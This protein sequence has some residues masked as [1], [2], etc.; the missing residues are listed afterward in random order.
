MEIERSLWTWWNPIVMKLVRIL[1][2]NE[3]LDRIQIVMKLDRNLVDMK[4]W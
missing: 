3:K 1:V 4:T 2:D